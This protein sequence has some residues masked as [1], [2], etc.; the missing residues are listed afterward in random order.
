MGN[1]FTQ[2]VKIYF[3]AVLAVFLTALGGVLYN[4]LYSVQQSLWD[5]SIKNIMESTARGAH[6]LQNSY[7]KDLDM[8]RM[9]AD[10]LEQTSS[11]HEDRIRRK[12]KIF[13]SHTGSISSLIFEDGTGYIDSGIAVSVTPEEKNF[14]RSLKESGVIEP[15]INRSTGRRTLVLYTAV[16]F[17]NGRR[18]Y[19]FKGYNVENLYTEYAL[20]FL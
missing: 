4:F 6:G 7:L 18:G 20:F 12:L 8:L 2:E 9:L 3:L 15:H 17:Q 10:E 1:E 11:E 14:I 19:L 16:H 5:N 13:L